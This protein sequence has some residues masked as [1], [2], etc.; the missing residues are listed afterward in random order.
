MEEEKLGKTKLDK[1]SE[2]I[3]CRE[4][5]EMERKWGWGGGYVTWRTKPKELMV[6]VEGLFW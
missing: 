1:S 3:R 4:A 2:V 6:G 5:W